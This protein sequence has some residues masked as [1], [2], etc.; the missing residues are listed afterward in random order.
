M[1]VLESDGWMLQ[2][3][4][5]ILKQNLA[6]DSTRSDQ[7][8]VEGFD[9]VRGHDHLDVATV[10]ESIK[11]IEKLEHGSLDFTFAARCGFITF[12]AYGI[13]L[14]DED[15]GWGM[16]GSDLV[17]VSLTTRHGPMTSVTNLKDLSD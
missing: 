14:V 12:G 1:V 13:D 4:V 11:L 5:R 15:N 7:R 17:R 16:I 2:H 9:L 8:R 3:T 6:I 10:I